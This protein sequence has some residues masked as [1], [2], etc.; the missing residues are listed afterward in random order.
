MSIVTVTGLTLVGGLGVASAQSSSNKK[1]NLVDKIATTFNL[2]RND[3]QK[4]FDQDRDE[5]KAKNEAKF[6][7]RLASA[8]KDGKLTQEQADKIKAKHDE[9][10][11]FMTS[12]RDKTTDE[13]HSAMKAKRAE[14]KKWAKDNNIPNQFV[15]FIHSQGAGRH[16][17]GVSPPDE[18]N[19]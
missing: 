19:S 1:D 9:L 11:T 7:E 5:R 4:V 3:V 17:H 18:S 16:N 13:R 8:V 14:L 15:R 12:L 2:D 10:K 6:E